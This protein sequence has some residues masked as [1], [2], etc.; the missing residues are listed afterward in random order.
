MCRTRFGVHF[1][2]WSGGAIARIVF[3]VANKRL[4]VKSASGVLPANKGLCAS[5]TRWREAGTWRGDSED[6]GGGVRVVELVGVTLGLACNSIY[7]VPQDRMEIPRGT[8]H[9]HI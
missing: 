4:R 1:C 7:F 8:F 9:F 5:I 3:R 6:E 2:Q